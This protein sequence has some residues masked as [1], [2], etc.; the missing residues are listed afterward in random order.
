MDT[1]TT[2]SNSTDRERWL[3]ARLKGVG[4]S[5]SPV[6]LGMSTFSS[7]VEL[8]GYKT[9]RLI[10]DEQDETDRMRWGRLLEPVVA[11]EYERQTGRELHYWGELL[12]SNEY[13]FLL[14]TPDY[15]TGEGIPVEI[16]TA[17]AERKSE[18]ADGP[19]PRVMCQMQH[20][21]AVTGA[22]M[23]STGVLVGGSTFM[24]ADVERDETMIAEIIQ[25]CRDFWAYVESDTSPPMDGSESTASAVARMWPNTAAGES[26]VLPDD[27]YD[28]HR[29]LAAAK[30]A[31]K[32]AQEQK[33]MI[34]NTVK[35]AIGNAE[36]GLFP[37]GSTAFTYRSQTRKEH[38][39][40]ESTF[41]VLRAKEM[42]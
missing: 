13:P 26:I 34:E 25:A 23:A 4:A 39:V 28:W 14:A 20:Q 3:Q 33:R 38:V 22:E 17:G 29:D 5:E 16:K 30:T 19:P 9:G 36:E 10:E 21:M 7:P 12:Q 32:M 1:Y 2:L 42:K 27:A 37:D 18:W 31:E 6:L 40:K 8:W 24:W 35:A 11:E 15:R 41:R